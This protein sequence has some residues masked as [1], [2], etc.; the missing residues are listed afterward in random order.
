MGRVY[1]AG[2]E[3]ER[4]ACFDCSAVAFFA[5]ARRNVAAPMLSNAQ[6]YSRC[7]AVQ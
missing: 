1:V 7:D 4:S 2:A 3:S 6:Y 5:L